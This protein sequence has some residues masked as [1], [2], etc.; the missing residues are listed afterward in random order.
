MR[1][2]AHKKEVSLHD[3]RG[4]ENLDFLGKTELVDTITRAW[5]TYTFVHKKENGYCNGIMSWERI[6]TV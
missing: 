1:R 2:S 4:S 5:K 3:M 6:G